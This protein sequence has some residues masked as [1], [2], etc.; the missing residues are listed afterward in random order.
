MYYNI[1]KNDKIV[2]DLDPIF[3]INFINGAY[4]DVKNSIGDKFDIYFIDKKNESICY[5]S[6]INNNCWCKSNIS[7]FVDWKIRIV[8]NGGEKTYEYEYDAGGKKVFIALESSSLGDTLAWIPYVE[9]FRKKWNCDVYVSTFWNNLFHN[10]YTELNFVS[11]GSVVSNIYAM[12]KIGWYYNESG[13]FN[14]LMNPLDFKKFSLQ[15][16]ASDI[17]GIE[18][19]QIKAK[20]NIPTVEKKKR[21]GLGINSTAQTKYWNNTTGWQEITDFL[22]LIGY[23]VVILSK[24]EDGYMGNFYPKGASKLPEGSISELVEFMLS[25][26]F[27]IGIGS[28]LSWLSWTLNIPTVL[29]SGF[30][31]PISEFTGDGVIR[32]FNEN[33][34]N[35]CY[36]RYKFDPSDWNWCP[37]QKGT[38]RQFECSKSITGGYV[39]NRLITEKI[40]SF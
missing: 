8:K 3:G 6:T 1:I 32:I 35:G 5:N 24:E 14:G 23:E 18:F 15:K 27:F 20:I 29:I 9:E 19:E 21:V 40:I 28:G 30:S 12:Y 38:N 34:C 16:T 11:P 4:V 31:T 17:L 26:E 13:D 25:C 39:I 2:R 37:D 36:N 33:V 7:Y 10:Q 22:K